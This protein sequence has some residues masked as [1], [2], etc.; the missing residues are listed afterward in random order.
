MTQSLIVVF[1]RDHMWDRV[2]DRLAT[3][4]HR[5]ANKKSSRKKESVS[6][7]LNQFLQIMPVPQ[8]L[9]SCQPMD[10]LRFLAY[11][12]ETGVGKTQVH[13]L[14]CPSLGQ[15]NIQICG[16]P[17]RLAAD[18]VRHL[19]SDI[20]VVLSKY[21][22]GFT[23]DSVSHTG[24]PA[25]SPEVMSYIAT[26]KDEQAEAHVVVKQAKPIPLEK[27]VALVTYL[28][29]EIE[30]KTLSLRDLFLF[31]RD[32]A[33]FLTQ[34]LLGER[35]GDLS[36]LLIQQIFLSPDNNTLILRQTYGKMRTE[37]HSVLL[38]SP[39][40]SLCPVKAIDIYVKQAIAMGI[41]MSTGY[42]FRKTLKDGNVIN[43]PLQQSG[44]NQRLVSHLTT[45]G[46]Y[47]GET[48]HSLR[49]GC[50]VA[51]TTTPHDSQESAAHI[52]WR[53]KACW[54]HY[55]RTSSFLSSS[56]AQS[57]STL[58]VDSQARAVADAQYSHLNSMSL[59]KAYD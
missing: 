40:P 10:I 1:Q 23:W 12:D 7:Q 43:A 53:S 41:D 51:L 4:A 57:I 19:V 13:D 46:Q 38:R 21:G 54:D 18:Y 37:K 20:K 2:E 11:K 24:N 50:A 3:L 47:Q 26:I 31:L 34:F 49:S 56:V 36:K 16:C 35:G 44:I 39:D 55:S 59:K 8:S 15:E 28:S 6:Q 17:V 58:L 5:N 9:E 33:F 30:S 42:L 52:G 29:K 48:T 45:I 32:K 14:E 25:M 27:I 22:R